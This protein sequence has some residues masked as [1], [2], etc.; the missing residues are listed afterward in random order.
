MK[1]IK[2]VQIGIGHDHATAILDSLLRQPDV[3]EVAALAVPENEK[4]DYADR[5]E[6]Y[7]KKIPVI[8]AGEALEFKDIDAVIVETEEKNLTKYAYTAAEKGLPVHID[9]PGGLELDDFEKLIN[10]VKENNTVFHIGYMYRYNESIIEAI[11]KAKSGEL[12]EV[13]CVEAHM[14]C[15]HSAEKRQWLSR[16][17]GGMMFY[18]GCHLIDIILQIMG[19]PEEIIQMNK[20]TGIDGVTG[21]DYGFTAFKYK[22]GVSFAKTC[23]AELGGFCRR[24]LVICGSK[25]TIELR[26]LEEYESDGN[27]H[28]GVKLT[29]YDKGRDW[30]Y[31]APVLNSEPVNR[32][33]FMMFNFAKMVCGEMKNP[34]DCDY[35]LT[36]YKTLL[37]SCGVCL[38]GKEKKQ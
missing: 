24:Q 5:I 14:D 38:D 21:E 35:E 34:F 4:S 26:P 20:A 9:K 6:K 17:P 31:S 16:F 32:Y 25:G 37:R 2:V 7:I 19:K 30:N 36:L 18:L 1:K 12:G 13:Y 8:S 11:R 22:N 23:A 33:D 29:D 10:L 28:T 15:W 27:L 3:F